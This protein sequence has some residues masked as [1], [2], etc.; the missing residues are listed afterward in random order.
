MADINPNDPNKVYTNA[1]RIIYFVL[2]ICGLMFTSILLLIL[3]KRL[4]KAK[5]RDIILTIIAVFVDCLSSCGLLFRAIFTQYPYNILK[6]HYYWC[7]FDGFL[8]AHMLIFSGFALSLLSAQRMLYLHFGG[9]LY[10][11]QF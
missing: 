3:G 11:K 1:L 10:T 6:E 7:A 4:K 5:H 2:S 9:K 8:N